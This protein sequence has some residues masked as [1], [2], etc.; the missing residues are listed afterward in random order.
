MEKGLFLKANKEVPSIEELQRNKLCFT[1]QQPWVLGHRCAKG[2]AH[3][4]EV[5]SKDD[6]DKLDE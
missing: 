5:F 3:Y 2:K 4:I 6:E 1:C